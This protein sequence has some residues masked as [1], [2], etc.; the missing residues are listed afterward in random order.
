MVLERWQGWKDE[1]K[2][3]LKGTRTSALDWR[4]CFFFSSLILGALPRSRWNE[5]VNFKCISP[6]SL[7]PWPVRSFIFCTSTEQTERKHPLG[8]ETKPAKINNAPSA[9][10]ATP[11]HTINNSAICLRCLACNMCKYW[12]HKSSFSLLQTTTTTNIFYCSCGLWGKECCSRRSFM[13]K[14]WKK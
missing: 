9:V 1:K 3:K 11:G 5:N 12:F 7:V 13:K 4:S 14:K 10:F 8:S 6:R 2:K